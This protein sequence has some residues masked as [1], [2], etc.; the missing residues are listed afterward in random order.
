MNFL[1]I[2]WSTTW[3]NQAMAE[4]IEN[5]L[6][7][8]NPDCNIEI[9]TWSEYVAEDLN[10]YD[11]TFIWS[12]TWWDWDIQDDMADLVTE[13]ENSK[14][15]T[16]HCAVFANWMSSFPKFCD[17]WKKITAALEKSWADIVWD[18]FE[19]DWDVYDRFDDL[20]EWVKSVL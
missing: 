8:E 6:R 3:N 13:I 2:Y 10:D 16:A 15:D 7:E 20:R 12:S 18:T 17:A 5:C 9:W 1:I 11:M 4:E 19:V 14:L